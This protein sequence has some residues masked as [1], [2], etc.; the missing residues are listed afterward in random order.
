MNTFAAIWN[1]PGHWVGSRLQ[2]KFVLLL[3]AILL[4]T[5]IAYVLL[6]HNQYKGQLL[7]EHA[8]ASMQVNR[9]LQTS[10]ENAMLKRD[11]PGLREIV[12]KL[13]Q[14]QDI[15]SVMIVNPQ[16]KVR[17]AS[18]RENM[19]RVLSDSAIAKAYSDKQGTTRTVYRESGEELLRSI[20][21]VQNRR[22]CNTCHGATADH[23]VNGLLIVD[24]KAASIRENA[25]RSA[26]TLIAIGSVTILATGAGLWIGLNRLV[27]SRIETLQSA[28]RKL[29]SGALHTRAALPGRDEI[30]DLGSSFDSMA[31][32]LGTSLRELEAS[33]QF[34]Q[35]IID[36]IPDGVRVIDETYT[37][38]KAN[39]A[40]CRQ[41]GA[42]KDRV[43][44][45][46]CYRS[47]H[48]R[49]TPCPYTLIDCPVKLLIDKPGSCIKTR[50][51][52]KTAD[53]TDLFVEVSAAQTELSTDAGQSPF[54]IESIR[55]LE[56]EASISHEQRLSEIGLLAAGVAHEIH[57]PLSS[58]ELALSALKDGSETPRSAG[59]I[60]E[61]LSIAKE[62]IDKCLEVTESMM[63]L[64][65]PPVDTIQLL[66]LDS[67]IPQVMALL[68]YEADTLKIHVE[69]ELENRLR[70]V[71]S[72][73]DM[74]MI[75]VNL[76]QNAF[77]AMVE[78]GNLIIRGRHARGWIVLSFLDDGV[79]IPASSLESIFLP[80]WTK[81]AGTSQG[82][83]LGL[84]LTKAIVDRLNGVIEVDSTVGS[85]TTF[86]V[87]LPDA[88]VED[89]SQ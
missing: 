42:G 57:N 82:R 4:A 32:R 55:N 25:L 24:Y 21:P 33:G 11:L 15:D 59:E 8:R 9:L 53:G 19:G 40:Y 17:F 38:I 78:G 16:F 65:Q 58:I 39:D 56:Q 74:R 44:G 23:P 69:L 75:T 43:I 51:H 30:S 83:G 6:V 70:V 41:I 85:G 52:H 64:S 60:H 37:I 89:Q 14:Q 48:K 26:L 13:G 46:K 47:S 71:A 77:H 50:H 87:R 63:R 61:Y 31:A 28:S 35:N 81:R 76:A 54:V 80:F 67:I 86:T 79:G 88:D 3:A 1:S 66:Q 29:S 45:E 7:N 49:D 72:D 84:S 2:R 20:I 27:L 10:L 12:N 34:L 5:S 73:S 22:V 62:E 18:E 36:A 68:A